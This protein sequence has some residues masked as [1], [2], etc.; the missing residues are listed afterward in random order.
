[1]ITGPVDPS[2]GWLVVDGL[3]R[4]LLL[5]PWESRR[6]IFGPFDI[7]IA[8]DMED[9]GD[10]RGGEVG[11]K[12]ESGNDIDAGI[13]FVGGCRGSNASGEVWREFIV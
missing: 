13:E 5:A 6:M 12:A 3:R 2:R 9:A 4:I 7:A 1:M 10:I 11:L 8:A